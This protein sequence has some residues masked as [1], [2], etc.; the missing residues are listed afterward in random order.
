[1][2]DDDGKYDKK[3]CC[4]ANAVCRV[5]LRSDSSLMLSSERGRKDERRKDEGSRDGKAGGETEQ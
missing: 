3:D 4:F 2:M 1:M 5:L